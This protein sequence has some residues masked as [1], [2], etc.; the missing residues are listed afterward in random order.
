MGWPVCGNCGEVA[1]FP[2]LGGMHACDA[3][4]L[5]EP[6][7]VRLEQPHPRRPDCGSRYHRVIK[8][9][10]I[11]GSELAHL[12]RYME[13]V[14]DDD[15]ITK[16]WVTVCADG[17]LEFRGAGFVYSARIGDEEPLRWEI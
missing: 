17:T 14:Q 10:S 9:I 3:G 8:R 4:E 11:E 12:E 16:L 6:L 15:E 2:W 5:I 7:T 1:Y 13:R